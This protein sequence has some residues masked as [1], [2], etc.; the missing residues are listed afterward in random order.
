MAERV[1][2]YFDPAC[3]WTWMTSRWL[4]EVA[5]QRP[6]H[7]EWRS[8]SLVILNEGG[9]VPHKYRMGRLAQRV[10]EALRSD[11]RNDDIGDLYREYGR[12]VHAGGRPPSAE[13][14][15]EAAVAAGLGDLAAAAH[16]PSWDHAIR[17][18]HEE[19]QEIAGPD[20][21]SPVLFREAVGRGTFGPIL[22]P[23]PVGADATRLWDTLVTLGELPQFYE[24]KRPRPDEPEI[25]P[26]LV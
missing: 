23:S 22:S 16:D 19:A 14:V 9:D 26:S 6:L 18:S 24:L 1:R 4:L 20:A 8:L 21:G 12:R 2:L 5:R 3:E 15:R 17:A 25:P 11:G 10:I 7:I 13:I